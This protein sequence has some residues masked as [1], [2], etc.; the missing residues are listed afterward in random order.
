MSRLVR[1]AEKGSLRRFRECLDAG[2]HASEELNRALRA[3]L[4]GAR[5]EKVRPLLAAGADPRWQNEEGSQLLTHAAVGGDADLVEL[6]LSLGCDP[7]HLSVHGRAPL[8]FAA[9]AGKVAA[10]AALIDAGAEV[11][12]RDAQGWTPLLD[13]LRSKAAAAACELILAGADVEARS[14]GERRTPLMLAALGAQVETARLLLRHGADLEAEDFT[15]CRALMHAAR[16][17]GAATVR[18]L[19]QAGADPAATDRQGKKA[20][21]WASPLAPQVAEL[22]LAHTPV[23]PDDLH[24]A[25]VAAAAGGQPSLV[26]KLLAQGAPV[27]PK[28]EGGTSA[29]ESAVGSRD[30]EIV[31]LLLRHPDTGVDYRC[32]RLRVTALMSAVRRG[33]LE[34]ARRLLE[35]GAD[36]EVRNTEGWT[37]NHEA[38][39]GGRRDLLEILTAAGAELE[40]SDRAGRR[41]LHVAAGSPGVRT[42]AE[43]RRI[44]VIDFLL[45]RGLRVDAGD[46]AG[47]TALVVAASHARPRVVRHLLAR[48][49]DANLR[50][51]G[52]DTA[53][54][55]AVGADADFGYNDR[56]VRPKSRR[57]DRAA[58]V[59]EALLAAGAD[60]SLYGRCGDPLAGAAL[61]RCPEVGRMLER[62]ARTAT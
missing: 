4:L 36:P 45:D 46:H 31:A 25:L 38:A 62:A 21:D 50:D 53:L 61:W 43:H 10:V 37:A 44:E 7:D 24:R 20:L 27:Q 47:A 13:A 52:G 19:L 12:P 57:N 35:A 41:L 33:K 54:S 40:V 14:P 15:G 6:F 32:H 60:P 26:S 23:G 42:P 56:Y 30:P 11:D 18:L 9:Y 28:A 22:L 17:G 55:H 8:H 51:A 48:G 3:A 59:I 39:A 5:A 16:Q 49:A 2:G 34:V 29:L 58:P 1:L